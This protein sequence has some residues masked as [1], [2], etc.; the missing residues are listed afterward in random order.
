M[1]RAAYRHRHWKDRKDIRYGQKLRAG[2]APHQELGNYNLLRAAKPDIH[3]PGYSS[4]D[5]RSIPADEIET[6]VVGHL[7]QFFTAPEIVHRVH[8]KAQQENPNI[9]A[10][11]VCERLGRFHEIWDQL[12]PLEQTRIIKLIVRR[13]D[14]SQQGVNI[15][16]QPNG[17]ME[18]Y[19]QIPGRRVAL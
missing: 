3:Q 19:A 8:L 11:E 14:V 16:Y 1:E 7:R 10:N 2:S 13:I 15:T 17:I 4:T 9:T 6:L 18:L 5:L 12:F